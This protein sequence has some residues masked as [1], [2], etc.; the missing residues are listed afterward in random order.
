MRLILTQKLIE[1][2]NSKY[3]ILIFVL[4]PFVAYS[5]IVDIPDANFKDALI[6]TICVDIDGIPGPDIDADI[7]NDGEIQLIEAQAVIN[8]L[9]V[10]GR[11][12]ASLEGIGSFSNLISLYCESNLLTELDLSQNLNLEYLDCGNGNLFSSLDLS[13]IPSIRGL[14]CVFSNLTSLIISNNL[15]LIS[16]RCNSNELTNIDLSGAPNLI[17]LAC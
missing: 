13:E 9:Y 12:I 15:N 5:Q 2:M 16:I 17:F 8:G 3:F 6:N 1:L 4:A 7:N 11:N 14:R 10:P